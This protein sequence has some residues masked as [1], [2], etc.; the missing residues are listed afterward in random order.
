MKKTIIN[1]GQQIFEF[2]EDEDDVSITKYEEHNGK[3]ENLGSLVLYRDQVET[4]VKIL[5]KF[6][7]SES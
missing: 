7:L 3:K 4:V 1:I 6:L 5:N 2:L